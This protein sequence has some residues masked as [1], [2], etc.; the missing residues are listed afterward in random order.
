MTISSNRLI[1]ACTKISITLTPSASNLNAPLEFRRNQDFHFMSSIQIDCNQSFSLNSTWAIYVCTAN[2][3][4][5]AQQVDPSIILKSTDLYIPARTLSIG[6]YQLELTVVVSGSSNVTAK[7]SAYVR[8]S[9]SGIIVNLFH[10]GTSFITS[11]YQR[12]L[13]MNP[14][15]FSVDSDGYDFNASVSDFMT[16][17]SH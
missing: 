14:G 1:L 2:C 6:V 5:I 7:R 10:M 9:Q 3:S 8:I 11:T 13:E 4:T 12:E 17:F 15:I 16:H